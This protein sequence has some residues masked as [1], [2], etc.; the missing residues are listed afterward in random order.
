MHAR[1]WPSVLE[2]ENLSAIFLPRI[3]LPLAFPSAPSFSLLPSVRP[4]RL[5]RGH[6]VYGWSE[7]G[8]KAD[9][10]PWI[11]GD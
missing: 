11:N 2:G 6:G 7:P 10:R 8:G 4:I 3:F 5:P 1:A 9:M